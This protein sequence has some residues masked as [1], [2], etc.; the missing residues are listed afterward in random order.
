L[1][2][3][4]MQRF[5]A[6][7]TV[8]VTGHTGF[9][10]SWLCRWLERLGA[11]VVGFSLPP[12]PMPDLFTLAKV[13]EG[14]TS[15]EGDVRDLGALSAVFAERR[16][17]IV[18]HLA[19]QALVRRGYRE[20]VDTF[21]TNVMGTV[22]VLEACRLCPST[23]AVVIV[24]SD[25]CYENREWVWGYREDE[26]MG[27]HDPYSASKACAELVT[28]AYRR[29]FVSQGRGPA[30]ASARAGNVIGGGDFAEDRLVP[31]IIRGIAA[32]E[33]IVIRNPLSTRP[34]QHVL[35]PLSGYLL[36]ARRL[37]DAPEAHAEAWNFGPS[38]EA[39]LPVG[40][41]ARRL[42]SILGHGTLEIAD[43]AP[44]GAPHEAAALKLDCSKARARLGWRPR[45]R[46]DD[47]LDLT[48][49]FYRAY[50]EEP[51]SVTAMLDRQI[52][53]YQSRPG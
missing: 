47:A 19:A 51:A 53:D 43:P 2:D 24:T 22:N 13:E 48:A 17:D 8:L 20:P 38:D 30:I 7:K 26:P 10:G 4:V 18:L 14:M 16:P 1:E 5:F 11:R 52:D 3:V 12:R 29:S 25:K 44:S 6:G 46:I 27:G 45:L 39:P 42:C 23:R 37:W 31:D 35:D 49:H 15:I 40:E 36:L 9:K 21:S 34:W 28:A 32:G 50:L 33:K 41:I